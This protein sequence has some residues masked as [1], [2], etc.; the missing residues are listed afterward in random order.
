MSKLPEV[1]IAASILFMRG[2]SANLAKLFD[3]EMPTK[4]KIDD[5]VVLYKKKWAIDEQSIMMAMC[6]AT[7]LDF[8]QSTI[9]VNIAPF[10]GPSFSD[11]LMVS[12][13]TTIDRFTD[14][15]THEII[16]VLLTDNTVY[17]NKSTGGVDLGDRWR[18]LFGSEHTMKT[19]V[20]IPVHAIHKHIYMNVLKQQS[21]HDNEME[22]L[23]QYN[24]LDYLAAWDY[25]DKVGYEKIIDMLKED[26]KKIEA[27]LAGTR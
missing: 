5:L 7:G 11:P 17:S 25:V 14:V 1:R 9:D 26:Y 6:Q 2:V 22:E 16:H 4:E 20:H 15:L 27:E 21:R 8:Y 24:A 13:R 12:S 19:L 3:A 18:E 23:R 10:I